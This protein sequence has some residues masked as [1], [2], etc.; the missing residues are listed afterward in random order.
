MNADLLNALKLTGRGMTAIFIV[1]LV[2]YFAVH[3]M[4]KL[5][6]RKKPDKADEKDPG[7]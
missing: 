5:S 7:K 1:M 4:L 2:I 6:N 3:L